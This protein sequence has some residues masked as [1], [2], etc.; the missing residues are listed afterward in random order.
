MQELIESFREE[1]EE[2]LTDLEAALLE[3]EER[4]D[5]L[6]LVDRA[7]RAM[8]TI[9][10]AGSMFGFGV[11]AA[12][13]HHLETFFD[14]VRNGELEVTKDLIDIG[15][16]A[17]DHVRALLDNPD[18]SSELE[19]AGTE[20]LERLS[21]L[22]PASVDNNP[23]AS[24]TVPLVPVIKEEAPDVTYR[25]R[26]KTAADAFVNG[27]DPLHLLQELTAL[28]S[29]QVTTL[30]GDVPELEALD[31]THCHL[32]FDVVLTTNRGRD[33]VED[34]F[35]FVQEGWD[36]V[37][38]VIDDG[39][40]AAEEKLIGEILVERGDAT[41]DQLAD[42]LS[43]QK[44][45]GELFVER[46]N[47]SREKVAAALAEQTAVRKLQQQRHDGENA[48]SVK[49]PADRLDS[50]MDL[51]GELVISQA[52]LSQ[53]ANGRADPELLSIAEET[54]RLTT[55]LR[56]TTLE[57]RMLAIGTTFARFRRLVRDL[58]AQLG[59]EIELLTE[60]A[61]T[62]LDK[63]VID[64]L[65]D[66]LVHLIR[67][68]IDHGIEAPERREAAGKPRKGTV[69]LSATH[70]ESH[71]VMRIEDDGAGL[72]AQAI[73]AKAVER[74]LIPP[75]AK[76]SEEE[77]F[78]LIFEPGFS[79]A[80]T[81]SNV[82]GRGVGMDVV[83]RSIESLRGKVRVTGQPGR[84][85][86]VTVELPLTLAIIEGLL[87]RVAEGRYVL[88]LSLVE[89]CIELT[90]LDADRANGNRLIEVRGDL[91]PYVRLREWFDEGG[92][93]PPIEQIVVT[94]LG[95]TRFGFTVDQVIGQH[96]TVIKSLGK[97]YE[98]VEGLAGGTI[99]GDGG[100]ALILD[101]PRLYHAAGAVGPVLH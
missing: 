21:A 54:E 65:G 42:V 41:P 28:G 11:L 14:E 76:P 93:R 34:V 74:G 92:A 47:V 81:V 91:V 66:P 9:K 63:T 16:C 2:L 10:G 1:A 26:I 90:Q 77:L 97:L 46:G 6:K 89:E 13:T 98:D 68:S 39:P 29:C 52:R 101:V 80:K 49:V 27:L 60:G 20:L 15:L 38:D 73:R 64:R 48:A 53:A 45:T 5:D 23:P 30:T 96:Q 24:E 35:I 51:V 8:H 32:A 44:R 55:E 99:L 57:L 67:N 36:I 4:P 83:K 75:D 94:R 62:E 85:T 87:V 78:N 31:A 17:R 37:I 100:V 18:P 79:T 95:E 12:F 70:S 22:M 25:I 3:L 40:Q 69:R 58:S 56:D 82:S 88:P 59:K 72:D 86:T 33:A 43:Q 71:V 19:T 7:F 84:G 50:L 61:E